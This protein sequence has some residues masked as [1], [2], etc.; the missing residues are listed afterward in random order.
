MKK[1]QLIIAL[2][3]LINIQAFA[4]TCYE[5]TTKQAINGAQIVMKGKVISKILTHNLSD[6]STIK[7][8]DTTNIH[9]VMAHRILMAVVKIKI[10]KLYKGKIS[11]DTITMITPKMSASCDFNF[12]IGDEYIVYATNHDTTF[13]S[14]KFERK[15]KDINTYWTDQ[16]S[17]TMLSNQSE[18]DQIKK[19]L[20]GKK[21]K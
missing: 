2:L 1:F 12:Q 7:T 6:I 4:C 8:S 5:I 21:S 15:S 14:S 10:N 18:E 17:R 3:C 16:C 9:Y 11:S 20:K 19:I 13:M